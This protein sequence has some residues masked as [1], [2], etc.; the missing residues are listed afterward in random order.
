ML[1]EKRVKHM[2]KLASYDTKYGSEDM[3]VS[4]Y[5]KNDYISLNLLFTFLWTTI[6][7]AILAVLLGLSYMDLLLEDLTLQKLLYIGGT[8]IGAYIVILTVTLIIAGRYF[9]KKHL[10]A[11]K[12]MKVY[13][14]NLDTLDHMYEQE[15]R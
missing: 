10:K 8:V 12:H 1:N 7:Y 11:R 5:F 15:A 4:T 6:S 9:K 13:R 3:K 2:V 14:A